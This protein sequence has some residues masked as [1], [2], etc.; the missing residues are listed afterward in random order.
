MP[1]WSNGPHS[2]CGE[3]VTVPGVRIPLSPQIAVIQQVTAIFLILIRTR[4]I[5]LIPYFETLE[6]FYEVLLATKL[7]TLVAKIRFST[8][9]VLEQ[10]KITSCS[11]FSFL[12]YTFVGVHFNGHKESMLFASALSW[13]C[14]NSPQQQIPLD[15]PVS[16]LLDW[17]THILVDSKQPSIRKD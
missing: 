5:V 6:A 15:L 4:S 9:L 16:I 7:A 8:N 10:R 1:E 13:R 11:F 17:N 12:I 2:K 3:R 14:G